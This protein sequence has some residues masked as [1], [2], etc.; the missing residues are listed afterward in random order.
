MLLKESIKCSAFLL[1]CTSLW[2]FSSLLVSHMNKCGFLP[3]ELKKH[4]LFRSIDGCFLLTNFPVSWKCQIYRVCY[5]KTSYKA[6]S[7][8]GNWAGCQGDCVLDNWLCFRSFLQM[9]SSYSFIHWTSLPFTQSFYWASAF[10]W[11]GNGK[12]MKWWKS[13][14]LTR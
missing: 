4:T 12:S 14:L 7:V 9:L 6:A 10:F 13:L 8:L 5:C 11:S 3:E 2:F 1:V